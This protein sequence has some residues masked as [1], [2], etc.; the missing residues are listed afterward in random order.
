MKTKLS[1][2]AVLAAISAPAAAGTI[3]LGVASNYNVFVFDNY[4][5]SQWGWSSI[6]GALAVGGNAN[7]TST[8]VSN[9]KNNQYKVVVGGVAT[10]NSWDSAVYNNTAGI[11]FAAA[12]SNL[13]GLSNS[14]YTAAATGSVE[15]K[16]GTGGYLTGTNSNVE[17]FTLDAANL[18]SIG[19]WQLSNIASGA[20]LIVNVYGS[21]VALTGGW[22][23]FGGYNTLFNFYDAKTINLNNINFSA[24]ILATE[25]TITGSSGSVNG[26]VVANNWNNSLTLGNGNGFVAIT[27]AVPEP[28]S[29][30][31][32]LAGLGVIGLTATRRKRIL[33]RS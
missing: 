25:A 17:Y 26:T 4:Q 33:A 11:N 5:T 30:A 32:L 7:L 23:A 19:N 12:K 10:V 13:S 2:L 22:D 24:S 29:Y 27:T 8:G 31:L 3:D 18:S 21:N 16:Y 9:S 15:Y 20:T 28:S 14:L 1:M 6:D